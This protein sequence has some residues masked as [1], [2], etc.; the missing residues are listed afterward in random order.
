MRKKEKIEMLLA[1]FLVFTKLQ[2]TIAFSI[3]KGLRKLR[4]K[5]DFL[6]VAFEKSEQNFVPFFQKGVMLKF[7]QLLPP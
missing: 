4:E 2:I 6:K 1:F 5:S 7:Y 3:P